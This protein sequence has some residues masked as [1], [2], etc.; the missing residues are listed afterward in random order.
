MM[1]PLLS[2]ISGRSNSENYGRQGGA[3]TDIEATKARR[4]RNQRAKP[5]AGPSYS[6]FV[7]WP[8]RPRSD[9]AW[10]PILESGHGGAFDPPPTVRYHLLYP[11]VKRVALV[12]VFAAA[13]LRA[14]TG[15]VSIET[16]SMPDVVYLDATTVPLES[17]PVVVEALPGKHFV[18]LFPPK[19]VYRAASEEAPE[20]FWDRLRKLGAIPEQ[21][22][23]ISS[24]EAGSVRVGTEWVYVA[25]EDTVKVKLSHAEVL[26][27]Y[28]RDTGCV[29]GT[30]IG[31]TI[32]I[33]ATM[34]LAIIFSRI[35]T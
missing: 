35:N 23:L 19:T 22:G 16:D 20:Q 21:P 2:I 14:A 11:H 8:L 32:G 24:Y 27:T 4:T 17:G 34:V 30:F 18:S 1:H 29:M 26:K 5:A 31:W 9:S 10:L 6:V 25:P 33:G 13:V 15:F 7:S 3:R 28:R 12:L